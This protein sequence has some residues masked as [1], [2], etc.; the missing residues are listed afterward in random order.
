M[1]NRSPSIASSHR[2][3]VARRACGI[4]LAAALAA[5]IVSVAPADASRC[6]ENLRGGGIH[7]D[8][9]DPTTLLGLCEPGST[10]V[11]YRLDQP[12]P[13]DGTKGEFEINSAPDSACAGKS[14]AVGMTGFIVG[15]WYPPDA[16]TGCR[17]VRLPNNGSMCLHLDGQSLGCS[18]DCADVSTEQIA[19][20]NAGG[21]DRRVC[22]PVDLN[23]TDIGRD[24]R[25]TRGSGE[26]KFRIWIGGLCATNGCVAADET[27]ACVTQWGA[28][29]WGYGKNKRGHQQEPG[30]YDWHTGAFK[31]TTWQGRPTCG[32]LGECL[33]KHTQKTPWQLTIVATPADGYMPPCLATEAATTCDAGP[34]FK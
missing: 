34:C 1:T 11:L 32:K 21:A 19:I 23:P 5:W 12:F 17:A 20:S 8:C 9:A 27:N 26:E 10:A 28:T 25:S 24:C 13:P 15:C 4:A 18:G 29:Q 22:P 2:S 30:W 3:R 31:L 33:G 16:K 7:C 14:T 6:S